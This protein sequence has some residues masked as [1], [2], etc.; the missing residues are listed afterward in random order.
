MA[1]NYK[2]YQRQASHRRPKR[3]RSANRGPLKIKPGADPLLKKV[4]SAIGVPRKT[5]FKADTYQLE[6]L[7]AVKT[8]DC[9][10]TAPTGAGKTWIALQAIERNIQR[11]ASAWYASPL[12]ALSNAK[13]EEFTE[14]FGPDNV[15]ILTGDRK[16]NPEAPV[17]VGTTEI[18]RNQLYDAM[19]R[20][21]SLSTD[22]VIL[23]EAHFLGDEDRGVVWEEIMI[24]LPPPD[25]A[26]DAF[27]HH[28]QCPPDCKLAHRDS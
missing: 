7:E 18:L 22:L 20:G 26:V 9:L 6:A 8:S 4:F 25:P 16:E 23:D 28:R 13:Y 17:I 5:P 15:G 14:H 11:G 19:D 10:V 1:R 3:Y 24:Y 27:G 12:K 21:E 2:Q